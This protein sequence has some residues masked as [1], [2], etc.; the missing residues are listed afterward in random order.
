MILYFSVD[1]CESGAV[2]KASLSAAWCR[3]PPEPEPVVCAR[4]G[5]RKCW[6][7]S[8]LSC[9][10]KGICHPLHNGGFVTAPAGLSRPSPAGGSSASPGSPRGW[11]CPQHLA[12][13]WFPPWTGR[14]GAVGFAGGF[15]GSK[16]I[17]KVFGGF[18][19]FNTRLRGQWGLSLAGVVSQACRKAVLEWSCISSPQP[20]QVS[21][22]RSICHHLPPWAASCSFHSFNLG[23]LCYQQEFGFGFFFTVGFIPSWMEYL[24]GASERNK[25]FCFPRNY[26][27]K[28]AGF[29]FLSSWRRELF[30]CGLTL[31]CSLITA[32]YQ[33]TTAPFWAGKCPS[34]P[35]EQSLLVPAFCFPQNNFLVDTFFLCVF[36]SNYFL[37]K[38]LKSMFL[39]DLW[40]CWCTQPL[41]RDMFMVGSELTLWSLCS[42]GLDVLSF[43]LQVMLRHWGHCWQS[44]LYLI[45]WPVSKFNSY[46]I[47]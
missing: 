22:S 38:S 41:L 5:S 12:R 4:A 36:D 11:S 19:L 34:N 3:C 7:F 20:S 24:L 45:L 26:K 1:S 25:W 47:R 21:G 40:P 30:T 17:G 46:R 13:P 28:L 14:C 39:V 18:L 32:S 27:Q 16:S 2:S 9:I 42:Q 15:L 43:P 31:F 8:H 33:M 23:C 35:T 6:F 37:M 10:T 29:P 44:R